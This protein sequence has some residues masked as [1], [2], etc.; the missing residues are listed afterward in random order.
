MKY[1]TGSVK[2]GRAEAECRAGPFV[3]THAA[4]Q[5]ATA[6]HRSSLARYVRYG[7]GQSFCNWLSLR[8]PRLAS[9]P[10]VRR[11]LADGAGAVRA[12]HRRAG[13]G[14]DGQEQCDE[15]QAARGPIR[16]ERD[17]C[18]RRRGGG[19]VPHQGQL[20]ICRESCREL[21]SA[22]AWAREL[23]DGCGV[24]RR[25]CGVGD[26][27]LVDMSRLSGRLSMHA[28]IPRG[29]TVTRVPPEKAARHAKQQSQLKL[30]NSKKLLADG[31]QAFF[32]RRLTVLTVL[33]AVS[34][35]PF[36]SRN[37]RG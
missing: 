32:L 21:R 6:L 4:Q 15:E 18:H 20:R 16:E 3:Y 11:G 12:A 37:E 19:G 25:V 24:E 35:W 34:S 17:R 10:E 30:C 26:V 7:S 2:R 33:P 22:A 13:E 9:A 28:C 14:G 29:P 5:P 31:T 23:C 27:W 1:K 36:R 8:K